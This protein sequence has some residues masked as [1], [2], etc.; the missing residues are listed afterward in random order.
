MDNVTENFIFNAV[1]FGI[2]KDSERKLYVRGDILGLADGIPD[3]N[4][5]IS[6][7]GTFS[8]TFIPDMDL[9]K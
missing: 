8:V 4:R 9:K 1:W 6:V 3:E 5:S 7:C 2:L